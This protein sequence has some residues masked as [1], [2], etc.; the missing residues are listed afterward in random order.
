L[1][2][3]GIRLAKPELPVINAGNRANPMYLPAQVCYVLPGQAANIKLDPAQ[4]Q[5]M[6]RFA[7]RG[8]AENATSITQQGL[9]TVGLSATTNPRLVSNLTS[10]CLDCPCRMPHGIESLQCP[11]CSHPRGLKARTLY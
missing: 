6:I 7:V 3:Y 5:Q 1:I 10:F 2:A 11:N 8:P 4:T 9:A